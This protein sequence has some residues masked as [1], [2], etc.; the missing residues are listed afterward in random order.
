[1]RMEHLSWSLT[2]QRE[3]WDQPGAVDF[4]G[5]RDYDQLEQLQARLETR[6]MRKNEESCSQ[7]QQLPGDDESGASLQQPQRSRKELTGAFIPQITS[8][9]SLFAIWARSIL[10]RARHE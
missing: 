2:G 3:L 1:M 6:K 10:G 5:K 8:L 9:T 4:W 7:I